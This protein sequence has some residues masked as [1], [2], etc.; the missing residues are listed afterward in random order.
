[1]EDGSDESQYGRAKRLGLIVGGA[2]FVVIL[3]TPPPAGLSTAGWRTAAVALLMAVWWMTEAIPIPATALLPLALFPTLGVLD[4]SNT[5]APYANDLIYLFLGGFLLAVT[6]ER[7]GLHK[8]IAL[9]IMAWVGTSP[10]R[11]VLGFMLATAFISMWI[12]NTATAAMMLPIA[13]AVGEMFRPQDH[14][15]PYEFGVA[16][17]LGVAFAASIGGIATLIGTPPNAVLAGAVSEMFHR[18]IGFLQWM[19]VGVPVAAVMLP[20]AWIVLTRFLYPPGQLSG[21][22]AAIIAA[23]RAK[24]G[25]PRRGE[26]L[27]GLVFGLTAAAW[28]LRS[29]K[30]FGSVTVPG[31]QSWAPSVSDSTI[32]IA[33]AMVLFLLPVDLKRGEFVLDWKTAKRIPWGV[34]VLFGGGLSLARAMDRSGLAEWIGGAVAGL[35]TIPTVLIIASVV[36]LFALLTEFTSN[37]ATATMAMPIMAGAAMGLGVE[38]VMLMT[39]ACLATSMAFML[40]AAT[41]PNALVFSSGYLTIP[42]MLKAGVVLDILAVGVITAAATFLIPYFLLR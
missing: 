6:M 35:G 39:T 37:T 34:L 5:A 27:T 36:A 33:A 29:P 25:A 17:M 32:A 30:T 11:L 42:Q 12:S 26:K 28:V 4:A 20:L 16:L 10:N 14:E 3:L 23:E 31:I 41:P 7:W 19:A 1:M 38:P 9:R 13:L 22:A 24:L 21:D 15:G 8:R 18:Q 40:P 2:V